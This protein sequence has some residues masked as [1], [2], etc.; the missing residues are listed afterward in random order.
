MP[1]PWVAGQ[2]QAKGEYARYG[3]LEPDGT[4]SVVNAIK[5]VCNCKVANLQADFIKDL[6]APGVTVTHSMTTFCGQSAAHVI[7]VGAATAAD[8]T[9]QNTDVFVFRDGS[10]AY[11]LMYRFRY[12]HPQASEEHALTAFC[13]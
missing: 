1:A 10:A 5:N 6:T 9:T 11:I 4:Y 13:P 2:F 3:E 7:A 8:K 12:P